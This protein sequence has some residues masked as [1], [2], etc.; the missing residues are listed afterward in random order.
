MGR[1]HRRVATLSRDCSG[2]QRDSHAAQGDGAGIQE[3]L[4]VC[5]DP[6]YKL[7]V[8]YSLVL[9]DLDKVNFRIK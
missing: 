3:A 2:S 7:S 4:N 8:F 1:M 5:P 6:E 9:P